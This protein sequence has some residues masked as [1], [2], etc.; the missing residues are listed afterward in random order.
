MT[1][2][3]RKKER[4]L[5]EREIGYAKNILSEY[6]VFRKILEARSSHGK[7][8]GNPRF[9]NK[10]RG[11]FSEM[12][13]AALRVKLFGLRRFILSHPDGD[14][15]LFLFLRYIHG[16]NMSV[17]A[18]RMGISERTAYRLHKRALAAVFLRLDEYEGGKSV[19][20]YE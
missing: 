11:A 3:R 14:E 19:R 9:L 15:K 20:C 17:C 12:S 6:T 1:G 2:K 13:D 5:N 18:E 16:E 4:S 8:F 7:A 10:E